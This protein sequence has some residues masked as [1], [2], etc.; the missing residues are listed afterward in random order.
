M[1]LKKMFAMSISVALISSIIVGCGNSETSSTNSD[2]K[3]PI[4]LKLAEN[5]SEDYPTTIGD[6]EFARLIEEKTEG[7]YKVDVYSG[8]QLGDEKSVIEQVQLGT[9]D[10]A[11]VNASPLTEFVN[12]IGVLSMPF[13]FKDEEHKWNVLNGDVGSELLDALKSANM[14]GLAYYDSGS[15][16]FYN[17]KKA[18]EKPEDLKGLKIRV[19]QS[20]LFISLVEALGGS[21][22]P[23]AYD[24][25]YS[26]I[27][28][29]VIDGAENNFPSYYSTNHYE[30]A[31]YYTL[32]NH[33]SVPE[34]LMASSSSWDK[35]SEDDQKL[36]YEAAVES[37]KVQREAWKAL[38]DESK[39]GIEKAGNTIIEVK[40]STP[41][42]EAVEP[43]YEEFGTAYNEWIDKIE[44]A[45]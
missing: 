40:D 9:I 43:V 41:W 5:Q 42:R 38:E 44:K 6:K 26:A 7:R 37:Q 25:V 31:K 3:K 8:G 35:L 45:E 27:Q 29:G 11:R 4:V 23:M 32:N 36:F 20:S 18:V 15:R 16:S 17:S 33:S 14:V 22:T 13:L 39:A 1:K 24:E 12:D 28:T 21:A 2:E 19:Q 10:L 34:V 30:V